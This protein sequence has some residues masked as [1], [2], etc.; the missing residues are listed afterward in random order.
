MYCQYFIK[1]YFISDSKTF[2]TAPCLTHRLCGKEVW[3]TGAAYQ[4][5]MNGRKYRPTGIQGLVKNPGKELATREFI[6]SY[7]D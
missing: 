2:V 6:T 1:S 7:A 5:I 3:T 4:F